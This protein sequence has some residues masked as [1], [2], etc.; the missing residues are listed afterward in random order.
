MDKAQIVE[1][2]NSCMWAIDGADLNYLV[3]KGFNPKLAKMGLQL[4]SYLEKKS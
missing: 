4:H 2:L 3:E 1:I